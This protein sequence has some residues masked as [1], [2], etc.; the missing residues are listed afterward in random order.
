MESNR[1]PLL[2]RE[3]YNSDEEYREAKRLHYGVSKEEE[4]ARKATKEHNKQVYTQGVYCEDVDTQYGKFTKVS[5]QVDKFMTNNTSPK[6]YIKFIIK[7]S[8]SGNLYAENI[9][10]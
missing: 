2:P 6:G 3:R 5:I 10:F 9:K 7:R 1:P 8:K 4:D